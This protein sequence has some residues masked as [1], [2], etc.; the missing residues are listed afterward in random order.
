MA[1]SIRRHK[2]ILFQIILDNLLFQRTAVIDMNGSSDYL[3]IFAYIDIISTGSGN[4][5]I[6]GGS[7]KE[8]NF[9]AY[10]IGS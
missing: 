3:E 6:N 2:L 8:A 7:D 1:V 9:G 4:P 10:R 5:R